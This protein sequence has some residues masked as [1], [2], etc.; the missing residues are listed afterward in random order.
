MSH[1]QFLCI[2]KLNRVHFYKEDNFVGFEEISGTIIH[3]DFIVN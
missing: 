1:I 2:H 3:D